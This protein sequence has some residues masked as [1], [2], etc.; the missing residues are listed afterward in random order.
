MHR[1]AIVFSLL[2]MTSV[3]AVKSRRVTA[4]DPAAER[5]LFGGGPSQ[6]ESRYD[7]PVARGPEQRHPLSS[8]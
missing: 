4:A 1:P 6:W 5:E 7:D 3:V 8:H 2:A